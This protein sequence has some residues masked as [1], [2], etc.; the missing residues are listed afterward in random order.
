MPLAKGAQNITI[1]AEVFAKLKQ[2]LVEK[3]QRNA[4]DENKKIG[5]FVNDLLVDVLEKDE[6]LSVMMPYYSPIGIHDNVLF[7]RDEKNK[8][9]AEIYLKDHMLYCDLDQTQDCEHIHFAYAIPEVAKLN[10]S[11]KSEKSKEDDIES[12]GQKVK[13]A[14]DKKRR[15]N[16]IIHK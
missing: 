11:S 12:D 9:V 8:K 15:S 14:S 10:I 16:P 7:I 1:R 2:K 3:Q 5:S 6:F 13:K 4:L